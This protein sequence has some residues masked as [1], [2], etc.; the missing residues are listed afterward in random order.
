MEIAVLEQAVN[1]AVVVKNGRTVLACEKA[2]A[3]ARDLGCDPAAVG[4]YCDEKKIKIV[5]C[6]LGCFK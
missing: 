2:L 1:A 4:K 6:K 5:Q 3:V